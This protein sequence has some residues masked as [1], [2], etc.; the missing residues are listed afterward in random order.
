M[1]VLSTSILESWAAII[2]AHSTEPDLI[3]DHESGFYVR[4][5]FIPNLCIFSKVPSTS[6]WVPY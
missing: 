5:V 4:Y 1:N 2:A 6:G 3:G